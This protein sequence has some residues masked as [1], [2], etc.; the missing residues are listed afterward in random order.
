MLMLSIVISGDG[1]FAVFP[2]DPHPD[3]TRSATLVPVVDGDH[4]TAAEQ[5]VRLAMALARDAVRSAAQG[6]A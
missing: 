6:E 3:Y 2:D 5:C 1:V 4:F